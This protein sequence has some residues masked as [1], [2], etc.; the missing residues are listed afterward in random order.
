M[1]ALILS[2]LIYIAAVFSHIY[3]LKSFLMHA[4]VVRCNLHFVIF[5]IFLFI[6]KLSKLA[7][8]STVNQDGLKFAIPLPQPPE[9]LNHQ[10][11]N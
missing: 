6:T 5:V 3:I 7:L 10:A 1:K 9:S 2:E 11:G 4:L 8:N